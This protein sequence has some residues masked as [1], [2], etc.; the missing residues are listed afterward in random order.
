M[1]QS[2]NCS[3]TVQHPSHWWKCLSN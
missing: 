1:Q 3:Y 2:E